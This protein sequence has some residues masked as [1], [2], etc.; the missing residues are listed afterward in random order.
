MN[1]EIINIIKDINN[2]KPQ[3]PNACVVTFGCQQNEADSERIKGMLV[4]MG[5]NITDTDMTGDISGSYGKFDENKNENENAFG[6]CDVIIMN[7]CAV[8]EHA[9]LKAFSRAGQLKHYK[10]KNK[11]LLVGLCGCMVEQ[12]HVLEYLKKSF[13]HVD[14]IFGTSSIHKFPEIF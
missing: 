7:T 12:E 2:Q 6:P 9:E 13:H 14:F 4:S 8:R 10:N 5:Y 1:E 11:N 3:K